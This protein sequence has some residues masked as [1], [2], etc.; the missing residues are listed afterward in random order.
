MSVVDANGLSRWP[1]PCPPLSVP[2]VGLGSRAP[3]GMVDGPGH[4][5]CTYRDSVPRKLEFDFQM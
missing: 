3:P 4:V 5:T 1:G 2:R